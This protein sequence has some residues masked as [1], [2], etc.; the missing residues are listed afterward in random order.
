MSTTASM[1]EPCSRKSPSDPI[2]RVLVVD[3]DPDLL[4]LLDLRLCSVGYS[5]GTASSAEQ[6]L[7]YLASER[8]SLLITDLRMTGMD[9]LGLLRAAKRLYP[10][11]P[12]ILLTAHGTIPDAVQATRQGAFGFVTKPFD[13]KELLEQVDS[14]LALSGSGSGSGADES[15]PTPAWRRDLVTCSPLMEDLLDQVGMVADGTARVLVSGQSGTGKEMVARAIH[16]A[17]GRRSKPFFAVNCGAIPEDLLESELFGHRKGAFTGAHTDHQ[18]LFQAAD[19]G[20]LLLDEIG[21]MPLTL[22]VKLLR[23]LEQNEVRPVGAVRPV[24]V[25]VRIVSATHRDLGSAIQDR[26]FREDL[27]YR[28]NVISLTIPPLRERR[29]DIPLLVEHFL[30]SI[31]RRHGARQRVFAPEGIELLARAPWPGNVRQL[32]NVVEQTVA[33]STGE[34]IPVS[35]VQRALGA[36]EDGIPPLAVAREGFE[37]DYLIRLLKVTNGNVAS[38]ARMAQRNRTEFY[39][40]LE[41]HKLKSATFRKHS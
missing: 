30:E 41:R 25:D 26:T 38:A 10:T 12:V 6:A 31:A 36:Q 9:G 35:L 17:S 37:R 4:R 27:Y 7:A 29:E 11:L 2:T 8:F 33:F 5:V 20:T 18:G 16:Q 15:E 32:Y 19:G 14:A 28:L 34:V 1:N 22:Q 39:R 23:V 3:D 21:D 13:P 40:L 24:A